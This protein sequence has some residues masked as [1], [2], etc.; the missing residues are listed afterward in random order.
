[1]KHIYSILIVTLIL[2][3]CSGEK[4]SCSNEE[5]EEEDGCCHN[6]PIFYKLFQNQELKVVEFESIEQLIVLNTVIPA[7]KIQLPSINKQL[8]Q[9]SNYTLPLIVYDRQVRFQTFLC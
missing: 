1:M 6:K 9:F 8:L 3:S 7:I 2:A 5:Q 4:M